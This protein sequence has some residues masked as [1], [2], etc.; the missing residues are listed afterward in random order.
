MNPSNPEK[1]AGSQASIEQIR[2]NAQVAFPLM[3]I[4]FGRILPGFLIILGVIIAAT[5]GPELG[6]AWSSRQWPTVQG[7]IVSSIVAS[8]NSHGQHGTYTFYYPQVVYEYAVDGRTF[9]GDRISFGT[10]GSDLKWKAEEATKLYPPGQEVAVHYRPAQPEASVLQPGVKG[11]N[12]W[13][14]LSSLIL[15]L[16]GFVMWRFAGRALDEQEARFRTIAQ[17]IELKKGEQP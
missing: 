1:P 15:L 17:Y 5:F 12:V 2:R 6:R 10:A 16:I 7:Q 11:L 3:R 4:L 14:T 13:P 8:G 9:Q